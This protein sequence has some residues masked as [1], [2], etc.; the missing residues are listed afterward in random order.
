MPLNPV[1]RAHLISPAGVG[2]LSVGKDGSTFITASLD[3]WFNDETASDNKVEIVT[4][5]F[6]VE[7]WRMQKFL[8]EEYFMLPPDYRNP[9]YYGLEKVNVK[10][11]IP[12]Y[13]FPTWHVCQD[14]GFLKQFPL[15]CILKPKCPVC[16][17]KG[18]TRYMSQVQI[19][20]VCEDGHLQD[21]PWREWVHA[22]DETQC[23]GHMNLSNPELRPFNFR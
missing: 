10:M 21:F 23:D 12:A 11:T 3:D 20:A 7:E 18:M 9:R 22:D 5:E 16:K 6:K 2:A 1:R 8:G 4:E 13:R 19:I 17:K 15:T 14:C